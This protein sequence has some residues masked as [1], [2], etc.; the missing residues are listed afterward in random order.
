M[1]R[2]KSKGNDQPVWMLKNI[3]SYLMF[4]HEYMTR[5]IKVLVLHVKFHLYFSKIRFKNSS[6][7]HTQYTSIMFIF[8]L[9]SP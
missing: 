3:L 6:V 4:V 7:P 5:F 8:R 9:L 2:A 1:Q